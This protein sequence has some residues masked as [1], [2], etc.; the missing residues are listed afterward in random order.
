LANVTEG[1]RSAT[2]GAAEYRPDR[3]VAFSV[4]AL[5]ED[6]ARTLALLRSKTELFLRAPG[7]PSVWKPALEKP[8]KQA[9]ALR[10]AR[11]QGGA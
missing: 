6:G 11:R 10:L 3:F 4:D 8:I 9:R 7:G 1:G 2:V 5:E